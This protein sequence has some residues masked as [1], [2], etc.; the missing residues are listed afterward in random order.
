[1]FFC[2]TFGIARFPMYHFHGADA[3][4]V[5]CFLLKTKH[6][7]Q[8]IYIYN[9]SK[10][11]PKQ[12]N[13]EPT[14]T[15]QTNMFALNAQQFGP[16]CSAVSPNCSAVWPKLLSNFT[17]LLSSLVSS[18]A[19]LLSSL[20]KL[21]TKLLSSL[22][23]IA[24]QFGETADQTAEQFCL[25]SYFFV[26]IVHFLF[27]FKVIFFDFCSKKTFKQMKIMLQ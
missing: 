11:K 7:T 8:H 25:D 20:V 4:L 21:L 6:P 19:K 14:S 13:F 12:H 26:K 1:M 23:Q 9:N 17:K 24:E 16:N 27:S 22:K 3:N 18:L 10:P 5:L 2:F 15:K